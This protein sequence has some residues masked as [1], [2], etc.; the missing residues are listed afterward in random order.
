M[1]IRRLEKYDLQEL[2]NIHKK[3]Y[4]FAFPDLSNP[5]YAF[6]RVVLDNSGKIVLAVIVKLTSEGIFITDKDTS[7][8]TR[9]KAIM[10]A[11]NSFKDAWSFGLEDCHTFVENDDHYI[12]IL[13]KLGWEDCTGHSL[14][15]I[16]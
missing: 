11:N 3:F 14:V 16:K 4:N 13:R 15:R 2:W 8:L 10:L 1:I 9:M 6:Q 7:N 5:L 12:N